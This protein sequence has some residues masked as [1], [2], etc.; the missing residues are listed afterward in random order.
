MAVTKSYKDNWDFQEGYY[1]QIQAILAQNALHFISFSVAD[2]E[3]DMKR[4]TDFIATVEDGAVAVRIRREDLLP[5]YRGELTIRSQ[6]GGHRTEL[7]KIRDGFG[8]YYLY[9]WENKDNELTRWMLISIDKLRNTGLIYDG[10]RTIPNTDGK[11][12]LVAYTWKELQDNDC[13]IAHQMD[14]WKHEQIEMF[15]TDN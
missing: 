3:S 12:G 7:H 15:S 2:R 13:I 10:R 8:K 4:A 5:R 14:G 11:T 9:C 6:Q 1:P